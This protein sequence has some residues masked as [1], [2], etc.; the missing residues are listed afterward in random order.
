MNGSDVLDCLEAETRG[1]A[2]SGHPGVPNGVLRDL[3][4]AIAEAAEK[5]AITPAQSE[6][7]VRIV[8]TVLGM[9]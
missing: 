4:K 6:A 1:G 3:P 7:L 8:N 2:G 5:G 9:I